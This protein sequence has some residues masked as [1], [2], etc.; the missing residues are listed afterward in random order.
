[1]SNCNHTDRPLTH[2]NKKGRPVSQCPHCRG[3]RKAR[4]SHVKCECGDKPHSK[5]DAHAE[6]SGI[7]REHGSRYQSPVR[8]DRSAVDQQACACRQGARCT[9]A[10]KKDNL[11]DFFPNPSKPGL[12]RSR[13]NNDGRNKPRLAGLHSDPSM[14]VFANGHHKPVHRNNHMGHE[15]GMPYKIPRPHSIHGSSSLARD[16]SDSLPLLLSGGDTGHQQ[17]LQQQ[18]QTSSYLLDSMAQ[19]Q[20]ERLVRSEH[21]SPGLR[22]KVELLGQLPQL[23]FSYTPLNTD[24]AASPLPTDYSQTY[25]NATAF[26]SYFS[27]AEEQQPVSAALSMPAVDWTAFDLPLD[28]GNYSATYSQAPSYASFDQPPTSHP[29]LT[30]TSSSGEVSEAEELMNVQS[31]SV[32]GGSPY[33]MVDE[34]SVMG[35]Y[36]LSTESFHSMATPPPT[37]MLPGSVTSAAMDSYIPTSI[38]SPRDFEDYNVGQKMKMEPEPFTPA[39]THHGFSVQEAQKLAHP[40]VKQEVLRELSPSSNIRPT[41]DPLWAASFDDPNFN[42]AVRTLQEPVWTS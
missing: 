25:G 34:H 19:H 33:R 42:P 30:T 2:I 31:P 28:G 21:G 10:L 23:D 26:D 32:H 36:S 35:P 37:S 5:L 17:Q 3:L 1:V 7:R 38:A 13:S 12:T 4:S 29:G 27:G 6:K 9:C 41:S 15:C 14:T 22:P 24:I 20:D 40:N 16:S 11:F 8:S 39:F 18:Q